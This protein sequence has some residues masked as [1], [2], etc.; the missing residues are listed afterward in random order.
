M[1]SILF[2]DKSIGE[3]SNISSDGDLWW[4]AYIELS[5]Y[6]KSLIGF[7]AVLVDEDSKDTNFDLFESDL[8]CDLYWYMVDIKQS[9]HQIEIPA[10]H[11]DEKLV[12]WRK[13]YP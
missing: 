5:E 8:M 6:G 12:M 13:I 10:I 11:L 2:K 3:L 1:P 7:F 9:H 4:S